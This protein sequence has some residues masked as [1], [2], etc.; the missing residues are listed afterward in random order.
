[1]KIR[2]L[3]VFVSL[4]CL[5][6]FVLNCESDS[7]SDDGDTTSQ[8]DTTG[9]GDTSGTDD[10]T[11]TMGEVDSELGLLVASCDSVG[12]SHSCTEWYSAPDFKDTIAENSDTTCDAIQGNWSLYGP[13]PTDGLLATCTTDIGGG[14][15]V[16]QIGYYYDEAGIA[17]GQA[18]CEG[19]GGVWEA[20]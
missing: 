4:L 17:T 19:S 12:A 1:M 3:F 5:S 11:T 14:A 6:V 9:T 20:K 18:I 13:C 10:T 2:R 8:A 16:V 15:E 7:G